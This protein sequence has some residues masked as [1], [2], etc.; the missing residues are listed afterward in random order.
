MDDDIA[1]TVVL[2]GFETNTIIRM[3][4]LAHFRGSHTCPCRS[5]L[6]STITLNRAVG[7][8]QASQAMA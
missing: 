3:F 7:T 2:L 1:P 5:P 4:V 8:G 6:L